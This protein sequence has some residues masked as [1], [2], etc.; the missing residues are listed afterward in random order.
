MTL[1]VIGTGFSRT[2]TDS[3]REALGMLG[4]SEAMPAEA[5]VLLEHNAPRRNRRGPFNYAPE[6]NRRSLS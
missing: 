2:G 3:M 6:L 4:F 1:K 5:A